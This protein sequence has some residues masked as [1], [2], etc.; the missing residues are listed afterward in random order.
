MGDKIDKDNWRCSVCGCKYDE[1]SRHCLESSSF[2]VNL[3]A[4][5]YS[6]MS[7]KGKIIDKSRSRRH[8]PQVCDICGSCKHV[9]QI[10]K[11][12]EYQGFLLCS[13]HYS[14]A[15]TYGEILTRTVFDKNEI[16]I[17]DDW[18]EV[19]LYDVKHNVIGSTKIDIED[20]EKVIMYKWSLNKARGYVY[21]GA[22]KALT[23][24][25]YLVN[26]DIVD[27]KNRDRLD[28]RKSNLREAS[29]GRNQRNA[30]LSKNNTSGITGVQW[31]KDRCTWGAFMVYDGTTFRKGGFKD[32]RDAIV[33]R[34][35]WEKEYFK[36]FAPQRH[37]FAEYGIIEEEADVDE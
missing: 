2:G 34:L 25:R 24:H 26:Y 31:R 12:G 27:H 6:Q 29:E 8:E 11:E 21:C 16:V 3:C 17:H 4:K 35:L 18:A 36:E 5:H 7:K 37:L 15:S 9:S 19:M 22:L 14:Q 32:K 30:N 20:V 10:R 1:T 23:L 28:N 33:Q 13:K